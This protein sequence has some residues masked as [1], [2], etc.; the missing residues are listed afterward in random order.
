M[1]VDCVLDLLPCNSL[2]C[3]IGETKGDR[4]RRKGNTHVNT[5]VHDAVSHTHAFLI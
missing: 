1:T 2:L 3:S 5:S 4:G